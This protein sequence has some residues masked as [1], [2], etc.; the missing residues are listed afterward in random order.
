[1]SIQTSLRWLA[2]AL[3]VTAVLGGGYWAVACPCA[4]VPGFV[5]LGAERTEP[6]QDWSFANDV[7]L[8]QVQ[9]STGLLP[10]SV[11]LN[12]MATPTGDLF[13]SCSAGTR[14]YWCQ[15]VGANHPGRLRLNGTV[16]PVVLNRVTDPA[17]LDAAWAARVKKLQNPDVQAVQPPGATPAPDAKRPDTW[18]SFRV[19]SRTS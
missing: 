16:Y 15:Q 18:W 12:C 17:T 10:H 11:N 8:C 7:T 9:I 5:L 13:L 19:R 1:M 3:V 2:A 6:V 4:G 14:K